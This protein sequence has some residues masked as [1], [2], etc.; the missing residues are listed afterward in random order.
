MS[1]DCSVY[2]S[3]RK[4]GMYIYVDREEGLSCIP[5]ELLGIIGKTAHVLDL[6]LTM[7]RRLATENTE[8]VLASIERQGFHLQMPPGEDEY[9]VHL[10]EELLR[11]ND[12]L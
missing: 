6:E 7:E 8:R 5:E 2:K 11:L 9:I 3:L 1:R 10:P 12:P 4:S